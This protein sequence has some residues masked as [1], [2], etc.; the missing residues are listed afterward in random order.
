VAP[1]LLALVYIIGVIWISSHH[2]IYRDE[3]RALSIILESNSI[4]DFFNILKAEGHPALWYIIIY[5]GWLLIKS[6]II[7]NITS[8]IIAIAAVIIFLFRSPFSFI[9]KALFIFRRKICD[10]NQ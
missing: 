1:C 9:Q 7:L 5:I 10:S 6:P 2:E 4:P 8:L 3:M